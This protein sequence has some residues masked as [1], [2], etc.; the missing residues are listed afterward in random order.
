MI[1]TQMSHH[2]TNPRKERPFLQHLIGPAIVGIIVLIGQYFINPVI[3]DK[4][5]KSDELQRSKQE[6]Y[7]AAVDLVDRFYLSLPWKTT[8][9]QA[10]NPKL[11]LR[12]EREEINQCF[13]KIILV[14]NDNVVSDAFLRCLGHSSER[15]FS[16]AFRDA[17]I[18]AMRHDL[19][20]TKPIALKESPL[21]FTLDNL[22]DTGPI[23]ALT[24]R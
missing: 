9:G 17:L 19:Y 18:N 13:A 23:S 12:P 1:L 2:T 14:E 3:A 22:I 24:N 6:V 8:D 11:G 10:M 7:L 15:G 16:V 5:A 20:A 21:F 4:E